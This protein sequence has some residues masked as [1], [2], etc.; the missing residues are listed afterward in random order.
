MRQI[1]GARAEFRASKQA[2]HADEL[3][4]AAVQ[5]GFPI[6]AAAGGDG[7]VHEV[8]NGILRS[9]NREVT[10]AV[11]PIGSANDY[12]YSLGIGA[13]WWECP[14]SA[15]AP[16]LVDV[17]VVRSGTRERFFLNGL[18][19][20]FNGSVTLESR[21]IRRLQG[22]FL[23]GL[24]L[25]RALIFHFRAIP[26]AVDIDGDLRHQAT[27]GLSLALGQR[28]G[29]FVVAPKASLEDGLFDYL[30]IGAL[31]RRHLPGLV[32][33]LFFGNLPDDHPSLRQGR[34]RH[35]AVEAAE[36]LTV[37]T[38]GEFFCVPSDGIDTID[39]E[40]LPARLRIFKRK[41]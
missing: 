38:D 37:H 34:C 3:A 4:F 6:V 8:G 28:E 41:N 40:C 12:A 23:Y 22:I 30:H 18:G 14:D 24:A 36:P 9:A 32:P 26:M 21:K 27:L 15:I 35:V 1:L 11:L 31:K 39:A 10:M 16:R 2:G 33:A 20:G 19:L 5:E 25:F 17:G 13:D 29:N 7:T